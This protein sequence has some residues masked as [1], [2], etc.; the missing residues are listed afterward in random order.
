MKQALEDQLPQ[1]I[2]VIKLGALGDMV[3][4]LGPM[5][6]IRQHHPDAHITALTTAPYEAFLRASG[7]VDDIWLDAKPRWSHPGA[8]LALRTR[9]RAAGFQRMY[10]LQTSSRSS[11]YF[12]LLWPGPI[13]E[14]S[15]V[16]RG[17]SHPHANPERDHMHTLDRQADQLSGAGIVHVPGIDLSWADADTR[18]FDLT[19]PICLMV[20]GGAPHRPAKRWPRDRYAALAR[21]LVGAG[22]TPV[23][24]G[25]A[26]EADLLS[27]I[28]RTCPTARNLCGETTLFD[29][30]ALARRAAGAVGNDT[31]PMHLLAAAGCPCT[32]LFS[33]ESEPSLCAPRGPAV[34]FLQRSQ[35]QDVSV[36]DVFTALQ[37]IAPG[38]PPFSLINGPVST[39]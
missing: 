14:W 19:E 8:W 16:A 31:G 35:L 4:A 32:V 29:L 27:S 38:L 13:P 10:D 34:N 25:A 7:Y 28:V 1:R 39:P 23:L 22:V 37:E 12:H 9:L 21:D 15:G 26:A 11:I 24:L 20:P 5:A 17:C 2:L 36:P 6:A 33:A 30:T 18:R 3:Q